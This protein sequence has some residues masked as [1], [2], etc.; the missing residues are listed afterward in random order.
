MNTFIQKWSEIIDILQNNLAFFPF[1]CAIF[2][3]ACLETHVRYDDLTTRYKVNKIELGIFKFFGGPLTF[4]L[5][6]VGAHCFKS[7]NILK[8]TYMTFISQQKI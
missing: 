2:V 8:T 3:F 1:F 5:T 7:H 4:L 6:T